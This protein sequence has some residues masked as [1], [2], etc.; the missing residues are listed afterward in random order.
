MA[1]RGGVLVTG[2]STGI[3]RACALGLDRAGFDVFAG[4]RKPEDGEALLADSSERLQPLIV[5][6]AD[7]NSIAVAADRVRRETGGRLA[8]LVNNA[9]IA[10]GGPIEALSLDDLRRQLETNVVG[11]V[12]V[13]QAF[14]AMIRAARGRVVFM[15][16]IG[17]R[18]G[19]P[20]ISPYNA[21]KHAIEAIGDALR[22]EMAPFGVEVSLI[23]PGA[24]ATPIWSKADAEVPRARAAIGPAMYELY[25]ERLDQLAAVAAKNAAAGIPPERVA[26]AVEHALTSHKPKTRYIVG[27]DAK[28]Q[29]RAKA[30][31]PDR[32]MDKLIDREFRTA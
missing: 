30:M 18:V 31:L 2:S 32:A 8:G 19:L 10:L 26:E 4:V 9:G 14:L 1:D 21:S 11:Q 22:M 24:I 16:S 6:V 17:G 28:L 7:G 15:S 23:E 13:T 25:G 3:G 29:A 20:F 27:R 5:D 12:A